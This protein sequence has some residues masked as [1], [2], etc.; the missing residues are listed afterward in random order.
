MVTFIAAC[1]SG[2]QMSHSQGGG[3]LAAEKNNTADWSRDEYGIPVVD[4]EEI[5]YETIYGDIHIRNCLFYSYT[6]DLTM[7]YF[8]EYPQISKFFEDSEEQYEIRKKINEQIYN[9]VID[10]AL[11]KWN[12]GI[13]FRYVEYEVTLIHDKW[14]SV[15]FRC[16]ISEGMRSWRSYKNITFNLET[17]K[18]VDANP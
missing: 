7:D 6:G 3:F 2:D 9:L 14:F 1:D 10:E 11:V 8:I 4:L 13:S 5:V 12:S 17:G 18:K 15:Y 16:D